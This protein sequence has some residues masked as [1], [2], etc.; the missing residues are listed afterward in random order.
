[1]VGQT[2]SFDTREQLEESFPIGTIEKMVHNFY[3]DVQADALLGPIFEERISD[4]PVHLERMVQFWRTVLRSES[5]FKPSKRGGPPQLHRQ[6]PGLR[7]EHYFHW[8]ALFGRVV[9]A[10]YPEAESVYVKGCAIR[11]AQ[12]LS[13]DLP[14]TKE[15]VS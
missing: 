7:R 6:L 15:K 14:P 13:Q 5:V 12:S 8:L 10:I 4:W 11:I 3:A 1:M 2:S 9:D